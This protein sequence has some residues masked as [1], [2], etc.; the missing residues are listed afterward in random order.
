M[1]PNA[2]S[3]KARAIGA[4]TGYGRQEQVL[5]TIVRVLLALALAA[6]LVV[7]GGWLTET[8]FPFIVGKAIFF[9]FVVEAAFVI[10]L[11]L[12]IQYPVYRL[13]RSWLLVSLL[14]YL[15]VALAAS[16]A[17]ISL[18]RS[19]WSTY[20]RMEG[21][22]TLGH[23]TMFALMLASVLR[24]FHHWQTVLNINILAGL[25]V[26]LLGLYEVAGGEEQRLSVTFGNPSFLASYVVV[27]LFIASAFLSHYLASFQ[28]S[29][30]AD[31]TSWPKALMLFFWVAAICLDL[32]ML[33]YSGTRGALVGL[34]VGAGMLLA[35]GF[36]W[37]EKRI[38]KMFCAAVLISLIAL[39]AVLLLIRQ[40]AI[41]VNVTQ[42]SPTLQRLIDVTPESPAVRSRLNSIYV[43]LE[44]FVER[45]VLGWGPANYGTAYESHVDGEAAVNLLIFDHAHNRIVEELV[46]T[47]V[48]GLAAYAAV[49]LCLI[50]IFVF[51]TKS[52]PFA[53]RL[54]M[55]LVGAG[56]A[57]YFVQNLFLFDT[58]AASVQY[59]L[60]LGFA[61]YMTSV[62]G[63]GF[64]RPGAGSADHRESR[65]DS[66]SSHGE[67]SDHDGACAICADGTHLSHDSVSVLPRGGW[68]LCRGQKHLY[69]PE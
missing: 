60:L 6:P 40:G 36:L 2:S 67:R 62:P 5:V 41:T 11:Y 64:I 4:Q 52:L 63:L 37:S 69:R 38:L 39:A 13:P 15:V 9:R 44:A 57:A 56:M 54:F 58:P 14:V 19:L 66:P 53:Q 20:E 55:V 18:T 16:F 31:T 24:T 61:L 32:L 35:A 27:N 29:G 33:N 30:A 23:L 28:E 49:W 26:G 65:S 68:P 22:I 46:V 47:G 25:V 50:W 59:Y 48:I 10:W 3:N 12:L 7:M 43:G 34:V 42:S 21:W 51:K 8:S 17:G 45:P 1:A